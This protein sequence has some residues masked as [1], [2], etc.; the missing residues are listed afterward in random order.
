MLRKLLRGMSVTAVLFLGMAI[1]YFF[2]PQIEKVINPLLE[3][4]NLKK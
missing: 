4:L 2:K 3:K 1:A